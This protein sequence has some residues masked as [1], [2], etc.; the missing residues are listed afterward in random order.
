VR[1][2]PLRPIG[3]EIR[4]ELAR[5]GPAAGMG[6][7]VAAW[8]EC[9]GP[10]IA[11]NAWPARLARDGTLHVATSS[12][13]WAFELTQ[14]AASILERLEAA[15]GDSK[16]AALRFAPGPIPEAEVP[17]EKASKRIVPEVDDEARTAAARIAAAIQDPGLRDAVARAAEVSLAAGSNR[18]IC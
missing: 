15:V 2:D 12:S 1:L 4:R 18:S 5:F 11:A 10:G 8:P 17:N 3:D 13:A 7:I 9:V 16:P 14:L 6:D